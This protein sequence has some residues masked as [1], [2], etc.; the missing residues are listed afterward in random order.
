MGPPVNP[1]RFTQS[2]RAE[3]EPAWK[4]GEFAG[5]AIILEKLLRSDHL[6]E[7]AAQRSSW[8]SCCAATRIPDPAAGTS[9]QQTRHRLPRSLPWKST[10]RAVPVTQNNFH[11]TE[12]DLTGTV[13]RPQHGYHGGLVR[14]RIARSLTP[15]EARRAGKRLME[16]G[17]AFQK[18]KLGPYPASSVTWGGEQVCGEC[19]I[20]NL[21]QFGDPAAQDDWPAPMLRLSSR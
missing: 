18:Q 11:L 3:F 21:G 2:H 6:G 9:K 14:V 17:K 20:G 1:V 13:I 16:A 8:R 10:G 12:D 19:G 7:A 15:E 4:E 5:A